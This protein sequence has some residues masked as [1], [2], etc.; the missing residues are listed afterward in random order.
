MSPGPPQGGPLTQ[1][2]GIDRVAGP[3]AHE[4]GQHVAVLSGALGM[5]HDHGGADMEAL[6][7]LGSVEERLRL[8]TE[9]LLWPAREPR[10]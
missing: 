5:L 1:V 2:D 6:R 4:L 9:D 10:P 7:I 3:L 8:L